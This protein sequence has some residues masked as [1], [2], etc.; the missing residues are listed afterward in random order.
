MDVLTGIHESTLKN[1]QDKSLEKRKQASNELQDIIE[2]LIAD[3]KF[4]VIY[5][6]IEMFTAM[7][8][9]ESGTERDNPQRRR[10]GLYGL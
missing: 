9:A 2:K 8:S 6:R 3:N 10:S 1:L 7:V 4:E 5:T